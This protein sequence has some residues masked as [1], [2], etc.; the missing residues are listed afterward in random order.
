MSLTESEQESK[1]L[2]TAEEEKLINNEEKGFDFDNPEFTFAP[3]G[4]HTW[5]A[6]GPYIICRSC[7]LEHA[8]FIGMN[9]LLVGIDKEGQPILKPR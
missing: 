8:I 6:E 4:F 9:K 3:K 7:E 1:T 2:L 5:R